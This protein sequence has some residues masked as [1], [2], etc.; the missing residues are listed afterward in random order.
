MRRYPEKWW[1]ETSFWIFN[2]NQPT[3]FH[4]ARYLWIRGMA[5]RDSE[6]RISS[7]RSVAWSEIPLPSRRSPRS[8]R[9]LSQCPGSARPPWSPG[10]Y[11]WAES[12]CP[13]SASSSSLG[14][15]RR[16]LA[17]S[18]PRRGHQSRAAPR[19]RR[20]P[21]GWAVL[22]PEP[23]PRSLRSAEERTPARLQSPMAKALESKRNPNLDAEIQRTTHSLSR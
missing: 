2:R 5:G 16:R 4:R 7:N 12:R 14:T 8:V 22:H 18:E 20:P 9:G 17:A 1:N 6:V 3:E 11:L 10:S 15:I 21:W 19:F 23:A 13:S